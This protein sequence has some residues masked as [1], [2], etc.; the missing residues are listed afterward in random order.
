MFLPRS[1]EQWPMT[2]QKHTVTTS[3][4]YIPPH[5][6]HG[7]MVPEFRSCPKHLY[8]PRRKPSAGIASRRQRR[9]TG[10]RESGSRKFRDQARMGGWRTWRRGDIF[11]FPLGRGVVHRA[12]A[13]R[14]IR[15]ATRTRYYLT[16][17]APVTVLPPGGAGHLRRGHGGYFGASGRIE[18]SGLVAAR[19]PI[20]LLRSR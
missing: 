18:G 14:Q 13:E 20:P 17:V 5:V 3:L 4:I 19:R 15:L 11:P 16:Q 10:R 12:R 1:L 6:R 9:R 8:D 2:N 7:L